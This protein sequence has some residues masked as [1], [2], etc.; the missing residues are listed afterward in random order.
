MTKETGKTSAWVGIA[1]SAIAVLITIF[2]FIGKISSQ[3]DVNSSMIQRA[4]ID[5]KSVDNSNKVEHK[6]LLEAIHAID[7]KVSILI[8]KRDDKNN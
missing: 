7:K 6:E 4:V 2:G 8:D 5:V 1:V 3:V